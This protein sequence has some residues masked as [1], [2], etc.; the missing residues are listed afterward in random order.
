MYSG[1]FGYDDFI[2]FAP[3]FGFNGGLRREET[4]Q[5]EV[6]F[7]QLLGS[8]SAL[9][10]TLFYKNI[11]GLVNDQNHDFQRTT[12]GETVT[13]I[14][15]ENADFGTTKGFAFSFDVTKLSYFNL[16]LQY[17]FSL[18]E[19]TGK[20]SYFNLSLQYTFSLAEGTGSTTSSSQ[21][22][23]FRNPDGEPPKVIAPLNFDQRHTG[24]MIVDFYI[25]EGEAGFWE[26]FNINALFSFA[27]GRPYTPTDNWNLLGDNGLSAENT[28]YINSAFG[29]GTFRIDLK[30]EKS[31]TIGDFYFVPY[32]WI[33]NLV[34]ATNV[35]RVYR[36]TGDPYTT[37]YL[38]TPGGISAI[39]NN[40]EG[41]AQDY[42]SLER[43]PR[44]FGIPRLIIG[45][46]I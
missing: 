18:A 45:I 8:N 39:A 14:Y 32:L 36:S 22:A 5:Y 38:N 43:N 44:N 16:S 20:L 19:G 26:M 1:P 10:L 11:K 34:G 23:V 42:E 7:R 37:G 29:P 28:G 31:F 13:A 46:L 6:G 35:T 40:G 15:P 4:T 9:N 17:T 2:S 25:P 12:G 41:F 24:V 21:T 33:E 3:Q 30:V 27:S